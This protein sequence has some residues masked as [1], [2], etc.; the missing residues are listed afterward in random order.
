MERVNACDVFSM[1]SVYFVHSMFLYSVILNLPKHA[2]IVSQC[3]FNV[4][5]CLHGYS[6]L[7]H[8]IYILK[9]LLKNDVLIFRMCHLEV[10]FNCL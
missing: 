9:S 7:I 8:T 6:K 4:K 5:L 10:R 1:V 3:M 2:L